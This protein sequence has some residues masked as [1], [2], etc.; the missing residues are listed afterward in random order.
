MRMYI[1]V[2]IYVRMIQVCSAY[3]P[4]DLR[5]AQVCALELCN[6]RCILKRTMFAFALKFHG[7]KKK[8]LQK[9]MKYVSR[10]LMWFLLPMLVVVAADLKKK[11]M[12]FVCQ[13]KRLLYFS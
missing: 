13:P 7:Q 8:H 1:Y 4:N 6:F 2:E 12:F 5:T 11:N 3:K 9:L 10:K